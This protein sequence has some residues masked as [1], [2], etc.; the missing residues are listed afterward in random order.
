MFTHSISPFMLVANYVLDDMS[1]RTSQCLAT[2]DSGDQQKG[3]I[4]SCTTS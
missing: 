2:I 3:N 4:K 1:P